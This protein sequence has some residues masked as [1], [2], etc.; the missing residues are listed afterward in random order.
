MKVMA[1]TQLIEKIYVELKDLK[2]EVVFIKKHMFDPDTIMTIDEAKRFEASLK[3]LKAGKTTPLSEL[4]KE[5][6]L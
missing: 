4:K 2:K 1:Q 6:G 5:L 3:E